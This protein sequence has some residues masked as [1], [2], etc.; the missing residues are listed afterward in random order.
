MNFNDVEE[1]RK[2]GFAGFNKMSELFL[3]SSSLPDIKGLYLVLYVDSLTPE[4]LGVGSGPR[5]YKKKTNPNVCIAELSAN[6][7]DNTKVVYIGKAGG[8]NQKGVEGKATIRKRLKTYLSFGKGNDVRHYGG[9]L[10]WQLKNHKDLIVCW[11]TTPNA[12]PRD[13]E[14][15]LIQQFV[16]KFSK[17][18]F[19]NLA[20]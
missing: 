19:A 14:V 16:S 6:W 12:E 5:L 3:D 2:A 17:R 4:F 18:P 8:K 20:D 10:I 1:I 13:I 9:R 11:K 7:V 15:D